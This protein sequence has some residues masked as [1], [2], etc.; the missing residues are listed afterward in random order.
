MTAADLNGDGRDDVAIA[1]V[2]STLPD[3]VLST[4]ST[5]VTYLS[6]ASGAPDARSE[7]AIDVGRS[8]GI[9]AADFDGDG[10]LDL[11]TAGGPASSTVATVSVFRGNGDGTLQ[12]PKQFAVPGPAL[13]HV[14]ADANGD[15]RADLIAGGGSGVTT[16]LNTTPRVNFGTYA[17]VRELK[18]LLENVLA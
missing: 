11:A 12:P 1:F 16:L 5:V 15:G 14:V 18:E 7:S 3:G 4:R 10:K 2:N 13:S 6:D 9:S 8:R 17:S